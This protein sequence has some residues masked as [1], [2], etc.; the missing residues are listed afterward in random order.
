MGLFDNMFGFLTGKGNEIDKPIYRKPYIDKTKDMLEL[1]RRLDQAPEESKPLFRG[2]ME[3]LG[4]KIEAHQRIN[5]ILAHSDLPIL[6]LYDLHILSTAGSASI[7]FVILSNR[8]IA[9]VSCPSQEDVLTASESRATAAPGETR[10]L[11]SS[12]HSAHILT[13]I[14]K[15]SGLVK[16][17]DLQM[18]WPVTILAEKPGEANFAEPLK[19][20]PSAHSEAYPGIHRAQTVKP[21]DFIKHLK[22][23][24]QFDD[25][26]SW[27]TNKEIIAVSDLLLKYEESTESSDDVQKG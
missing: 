16:K 21:E 5:D 14:L 26:F 22:Q 6:I 7:D 23:L 19:S 15:T 20:V 13:E 9:A 27:L 4:Q 8:F 3:T 10:H 17:K 2:A 24:F 25:A 11:S 18:I 12:E 1:A